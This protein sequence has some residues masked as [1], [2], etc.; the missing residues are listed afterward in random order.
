MNKKSIK[1]TRM[2]IYNGEKA[3]CEQCGEEGQKLYMAHNIYGEYTCRNCI[4]MDVIGL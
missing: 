3:M 2:Y 4:E 1:E